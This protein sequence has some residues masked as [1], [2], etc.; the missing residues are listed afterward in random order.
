MIAIFL[1]IP[2]AT[3]VIKTRWFL[4]KKFHEFIG[5]TKIKFGKSFRVLR[6]EYKPPTNKRN[7]EQLLSFEVDIESKLKGNDRQAVSL[8]ELFNIQKKF[9]L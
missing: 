3:A 5:F 4:G 6:I 9:C 1:P 8:K 7:S 2:E